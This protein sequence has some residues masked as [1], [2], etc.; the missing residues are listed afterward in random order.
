MRVTEPAAGEGKEHTCPMHP[1]I[2]KDAPGSCPVCGMA[3]EPRTATA[4]EEE[5]PELMD[6]RG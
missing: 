2:V 6:M 4:K 5:N 3:L 1:E